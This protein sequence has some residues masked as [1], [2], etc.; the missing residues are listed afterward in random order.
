MSETLPDSNDG[1][2]KSDRNVQV[3]G[4]GPKTFVTPYTELIDYHPFVQQLLP[5]VR[6]FGYVWFHLQAFKRKKIKNGKKPTVEEMDKIKRDILNRDKNEKQTWAVH[7]L[8]KLRKDIQLNDR[9]VFIETIQSNDHTRCVLSNPDHKGKMRRIDCL[10]QADKVW[11]I[12]LVM[13]VLF[14]AVPL[15][16][17]D[18][19]RIEKSTQCINHDLCVNPFHMSLAAR[20]LDLYMSLRFI[21]EKQTQSRD[22]EQESDEDDLCIAI[23]PATDFIPIEKDIHGSSV[24]GAAE[25]KR[26][27]GY[28]IFKPSKSDQLILPEKR[29]LIKR[30]IVITPDPIPQK[31]SSNKDTERVNSSQKN[32][33]KKES[34]PVPPSNK[35]ISPRKRGQTKRNSD[36]SLETANK[37]DN[38][39]EESSIMS[40]TA[41]LETSAYPQSPPKLNKIFDLRKIPPIPHNLFEEDIF[42]SITKVLNASTK[43]AFKKYLDA[44]SKKKVTGS[45][46]LTPE[47]QRKTAPR[48]PGNYNYHTSYDGGVEHEKVLRKEVEVVDK[49]LSPEDTNDSSKVSSD[50]FN[51]SNS[52]SNSSTIDSSDEVSVVL[53]GENSNATILHTPKAIHGTALKSFQLP[54]NLFPNPT[55]TIQKASLIP[56]ALYVTGD[57][58]YASPEASFSIGD[59]GYPSSQLSNQPINNG[60]SSFVN[61]NRS[62]NNMTGIAVNTFPIS[63]ANLTPSSTD[64]LLYTNFIQT[65]SAASKKVDASSLSNLEQQLKSNL[66]AGAST[67]MP[68][69]NSDIASLPAFRNNYEIIEKYAILQKEKTGSAHFPPYLTEAVNKLNRPSNNFLHY[70]TVMNQK[71]AAARNAALEQQKNIRII[72]ATP[73]NRNNPP[74]PSSTSSGV[75]K[76]TKP[77]PQPPNSLVHM[78]SPYVAPNKSPTDN[79][80]KK[81]IKTE[82][83]TPRIMKIPSLV[84]TPESPHKPVTRQSASQPLNLNLVK[85]GT[86]RSLANDAKEINKKARK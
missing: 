34:V 61:I 21:Q 59:P 13:L 25:F 62:P 32:L 31:N 26:I 22:S 66:S 60:Y 73:H 43:T 63:T 52:N 10:R 71:N 9:D 36:Q 70:Q 16:S 19:E 80:V 75:L 84:N 72:V 46:E 23:P 45:M 58:K 12:D 15:E 69:P 29:E 74:T 5:H 27:T 57:S 77:M 37:K 53:N 30:C 1:I 33:S 28:N 14:K 86:K 83:K 39:T 54:A 79:E 85:N 82:S 7:L 41:N 20:E 6:E 4:E 51:Y 55:T 64:K 3:T 67:F 35:T 65:I 68:N 17:T 42:P 2:I 40:Q 47:T 8:N 76:F 24:F 56:N 38:S 48:K 18:G 50:I 11:R 78:R 49:S 81:E 44:D